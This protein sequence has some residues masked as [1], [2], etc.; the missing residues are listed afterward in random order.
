MNFDKRAKK[1]LKVY[2]EEDPLSFMTTAESFS[3]KDLIRRDVQYQILRE[4][5]DIPSF[6]DWVKS[7]YKLEKDSSVI[8]NFYDVTKRTLFRI[9]MED[10]N[11]DV[12]PS[13]NKLRQSILLKSLPEEDRL[14]THLPPISPEYLEYIKD[15]YGEFYDYFTNKETRERFKLYA[16][17]EEV[18]YIK[19]IYNIQ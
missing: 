13:D 1:I 10:N 15:S 16:V 19:E 2:Y 12:I 8:E 5:L 11:I 4:T 17:D 7:D 3:K 9:Y 18:E 6:K 14:F